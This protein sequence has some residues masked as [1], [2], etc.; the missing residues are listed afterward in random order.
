MRVTP[1]P[2]KSRRPCRPQGCSLLERRS[3]D[4][5]DCSRPCGG[6]LAYPEHEP[7]MAAAFHAADPTT[8]DAAACDAAAFHAADPTTCDAAACDAAAFHAADATASDA[9]AS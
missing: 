4:E 2:S 5:I 7:R 9:A 8:C 1:L 6:E 3:G